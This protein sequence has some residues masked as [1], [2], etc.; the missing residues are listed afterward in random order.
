MK[1]RMG[2][3]VLACFALSCVVDLAAIAFAHFYPEKALLFAHMNGVVFYGLPVALCGVLGVS[4]NIWSRHSIARNFLASL[5][6]LLVPFAAAV[7]GVY[8]SCLTLRECL[9]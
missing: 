2:S 5:I 9:L 7:V 3:F 1:P 4:M 8:L 6:C